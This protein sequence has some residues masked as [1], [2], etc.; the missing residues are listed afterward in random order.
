[1]LIT[2]ASA[3][4]SSGG[5]EYMIPAHRGT[6]MPTQPTAISASRAVRPF[7]KRYDTAVGLKADATTPR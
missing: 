1:M 3:S 2:T 5:R 4:G 6:T 7:S